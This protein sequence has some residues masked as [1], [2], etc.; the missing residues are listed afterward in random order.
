MRIVIFIDANTVI[1]RRLVRA[2]L[3]A[4][5]EGG[6]R[7]VV[8]VVTTAP[9]AFPSGSRAV[10]RE[11]ALRALV[12]ASN[13][14]VSLRS[15]FEPRL[16]L[17]RL[18]SRR[19]IPV[20]VPPTSNPNDTRFVRDVVSA[21]RPDVALSYY[22]RHRFRRRLL[23]SFAQAV[24]FHDGLLPDYR[25]VMAT[26]FS[27]LAG[28][29][30]SGLTFHHMSAEIDR[31]P[32]LFEDWVPAG[33]RA[34][35]REVSR[36]KAARAANAVPRV[37]DLLAAGDPGR[38]QDGEGSY[39][40]AHDWAALT[41]LSEPA[42]ATSEQIRRRIRAFGAV[43]LDIAGQSWPVTRLRPARPG[44][45][46]AFRTEDGQLLRPDRFLGLPAVVYRRVERRR[47]ATR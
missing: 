27:I 36:A 13:R 11:L 3:S 34:T 33:A 14:E 5:R 40:S 46:L 30:R 1:T 7:R 41:H 20:L 26:S 18:C 12:A 23:S 39:F 44:E 43:R 24:N 15:L 6:D 29:E 9:D 38:P 25:G 32:I 17:F 42:N 8:G 28:E 37:L 21:L 31:G 45:R 16:D 35:V 22:C 4:A 47:H 10:A 19:G 2:T